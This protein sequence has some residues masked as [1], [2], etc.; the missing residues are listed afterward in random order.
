MQLGE[1]DMCDVLICAGSTGWG[2]GGGTNICKP[3]SGI[4]WVVAST[5]W[6][7]AAFNCNSTR[8]RGARTNPNID[9]RL[10]VDTRAVGRSTHC[11]CTESERTEWCRPTTGSSCTV[12]NRSKLMVVRSD[13][14]GVVS[15][16]CHNASTVNQFGMR[17]LE[18]YCVLSEE[19]KRKLH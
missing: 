5:S 2:I 10:G 15:F 9:I 16:K 8:A 18:Q 6:V 11:H 7:S 14:S 3:G 13:S 12:N 17:R 19:I 1:Y 4:I